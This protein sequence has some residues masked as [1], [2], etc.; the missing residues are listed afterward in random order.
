M[1]LLIVSLFPCG[2]ST[3]TNSMLESESVATKTRLRD[4]RSISLLGIGQSRR[5]TRALSAAPSAPSALSHCQ[6][7]RETKCHPRPAR[8][9]NAVTV[10]Q[11]VVAGQ[12]GQLRPGVR[13]PTRLRG[14]APTPENQRSARSPRAAQ[15][16][17]SR[18]RRRSGR[19]GLHCGFRPCDRRGVTRATA[20]TTQPRALA[21]AGTLSYSAPGACERHAR[22]RHS[23]VQHRA[24]R[25][26]SGAS[27]PRI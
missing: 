18:S 23:G 8:R 2:L 25:R 14:S 24:E 5:R 9:W 15:T 6:E 11:S 4:R 13:I 21:A 12:G 27:G 7:F 16:V 19:R 10:Q 17:R 20:A 1:A 3:A 22:S 26:T